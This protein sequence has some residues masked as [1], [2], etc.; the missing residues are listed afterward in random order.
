MRRLLPSAA[1]VSGHVTT[2]VSSIYSLSFTF[3]NGQWRPRATSDGHHGGGPR[4]RA[5]AQARRLLG[6]PQARNHEKVTYC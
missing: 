4:D 1:P 6:G 3:G 2:C 5:A